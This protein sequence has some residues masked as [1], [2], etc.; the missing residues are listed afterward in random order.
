MKDYN[1]QNLRNIAFI[2]HSGSGKTTLAEAMLYYTKT[3]D[4]FGKVEDGNTISDYDPEEKEG[5]FLYLHQFYP[6]NGKM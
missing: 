4:R 6:V 1:V 5:R 2:G 3:I